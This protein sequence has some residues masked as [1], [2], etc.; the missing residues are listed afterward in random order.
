M[1]AATL[2]RILTIEKLIKRTIVLVDWCCKYKDDM[3]IADHL[4]R[5]HLLHFFKF[6]VHWVMPS[7]VIDDLFCGKR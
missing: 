2:N 5:H 4:L 7:K 1:W 6:G 3:E